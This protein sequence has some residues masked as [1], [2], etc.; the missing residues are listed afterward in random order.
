MKRD[1]TLLEKRQ[2]FVIAYINERNSTMLMKNIV[3]ELQERLFLSERTI[4]N[5]YTS[6]KPVKKRTKSKSV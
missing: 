6:Y 2:E 4:Y 5:I 3:I 1:K